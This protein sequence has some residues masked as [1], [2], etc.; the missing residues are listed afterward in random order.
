MTEYLWKEKYLR[1]IDLFLG[2]LSRFAIF[3]GLIQ[4]LSQ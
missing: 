3:G 1:Q 2:N 4:G